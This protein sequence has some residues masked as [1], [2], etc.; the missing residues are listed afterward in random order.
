ML[1]FII[2]HVFTEIFISSYSLKFLSSVLS[3]LF[4][5]LLNGLPCALGLWTE[6]WATL[7][8]R[9]RQASSILP[10]CPASSPHDGDLLQGEM[11]LESGEGSWEAHVG[12]AP[13]SSPQR[14]RGRQY[15]AHTFY[16]WPSTVWGRVGPDTALFLLRSRWTSSLPVLA[17]FLSSCGQSVEL[18]NALPLG[19]P[20][21][22]ALCWVGC[23][24]VDIAS[25]SERPH[26]QMS[27]SGVVDFTFGARM[28]CWQ[29]VLLA[30]LEE[31]HFDICSKGQLRVL[32][33]VEGWK[34]C[35]RWWD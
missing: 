4:P 20:E 31:D 30:C 8:E 12:A 11:G 7:Q 17:S 13:G 2:V 33:G 29:V 22:R 9:G 21:A 27:V 5:G 16:T 6:K 19:F 1:A 28:P 34:L 23:I 26:H 35:A 18:E 3:L 24:A 10:Q 25:V 15:G 32:T 14:A